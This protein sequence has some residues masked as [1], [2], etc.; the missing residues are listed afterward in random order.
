LRFPWCISPLR[1]LEKPIK[2]STEARSSL[3]KK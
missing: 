1:L 3:H 2:A